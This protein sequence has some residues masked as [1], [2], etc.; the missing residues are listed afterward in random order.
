VNLL[1]HNLFMNV[2]HQ[3]PKSICF[4]RGRKSLWEGCQPSVCLLDGSQS[5]A[6]GSVTICWKVE[7]WGRPRVLRGVTPHSPLPLPDSKVNNK[8]QGKPFLKCSDIII[9][10]NT[11]P[12]HAATSPHLKNKNKIF[13]ENIALLEV[14]DS[15]FVCC[16]LIFVPVIFMILHTV[17]FR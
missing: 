10:P 15:L 2:S 3:V 8:V 5:S 6:G 9:I 17:F 1:F 14:E 7:W 4:I 16:C 11:G 13:Y 12:R